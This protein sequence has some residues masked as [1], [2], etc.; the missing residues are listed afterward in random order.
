MHSF[1]FLFIIPGGIFPEKRCFMAIRKIIILSLIL[2]L[3]LCLF[4]ESTSA[5]IC[6]C[7]KCCHKATQD[8]TDTDTIFTSGQ[9]SPGGGAFKNCRL[10]SGDYLKTIHFFK[11][12]LNGK[13]LN[14]FSGLDSGGIFSFGTYPS[15]FLYVEVADFQS[16]PVYIQNLSFRC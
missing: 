12:N 8:K 10:K 5:G 3:T 2:S 6:Y 13:I 9:G 1:F 7:E 11:K 14:A 4:I 15:N 16:Q